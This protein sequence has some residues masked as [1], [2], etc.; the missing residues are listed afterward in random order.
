MRR[1]LSSDVPNVFQKIFVSREAISAM[2]FAYLIEAGASSNEPGHQ[3]I[4]RRE[5]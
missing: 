1:S 5:L 4:K 2:V 3:R